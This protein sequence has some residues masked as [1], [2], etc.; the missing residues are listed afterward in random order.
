LSP[1]RARMQGMAAHRIPRRGQK[2]HIDGQPGT[3]VVVRV[4]KVNSFA[5][6]EQWDDPRVVVWDVP[7]EAIHLI[8]EPMNEAA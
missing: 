7:F 8:H 5:T 2:V 4:D 3:L 1:G 6:V